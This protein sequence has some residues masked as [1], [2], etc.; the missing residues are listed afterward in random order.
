MPKY[1]TTEAQ[2]DA[3]RIVSDKLFSVKVSNDKGDI[4]LNVLADSGEHA[5]EK[6]ATWIIE[7]S[8]DWNYVTAYPTLNAI[9][10]I[11]K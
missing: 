6:A 3:I 2:R 11:I 10:E 8:I 5:Q 7:N 9:E 1:T 4:W